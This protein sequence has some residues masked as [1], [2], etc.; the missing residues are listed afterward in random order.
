MNTKALLEQAKAAME[1]GFTAAGAELEKK[2][3]RARKLALAYE[4]YRYVSQKKIDDFKSRLLQATRRR[5]TEAEAMH[6]ATTLM[7]MYQTIGQILSSASD[8]YDALVL[9][10]LEKYVGL[11]P[12]DVLATVKVARGRGIFDRMEVAHVEPVAT[13]IH[14]PDPIV[15][16]LVDGCTDR[17]YIAEWGN[18]VSINDLLADNEG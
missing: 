5:P 17:F 2:A 6:E 1:A 11:P 10:P 18:D 7:L 12:A 14:Y 8:V 9:D 16:G 13:Q 3:E 4:H 15:F